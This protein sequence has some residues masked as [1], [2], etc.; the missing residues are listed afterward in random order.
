MQKT[1]KLMSNRRSEYYPVISY[2]FALVIIWLASW[3]ASVVQM[4]MFADSTVHSIVSAEGVRWALLSMHGSL[5]GVPWGSAL[6]LLFAAGLLTGSG[7]IH[8]LSRLMTGK[9]ISG[10]EVRSLLFSA[11]VLFLYIA[12]VFMFTVTPW[13]AMLG[14]T[15]E[16]ALSPLAQGW[17]LVLFVGVLVVSLVFGFMYGNYRTLA[18]VVGSA[19]VYMTIFLPAL[20]AMLPAA[21]I[22]PCLE[23]SGFA[24]MIGLDE[25]CADIAVELLCVFPF[26]YVAILWAMQKRER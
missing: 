10:N 17:M 16:V 15:G 24:A 5:N 18:D 14:V 19:G 25:E 21:G 11:L 6:L 7:I 9:K 26:L 12:I 8:S 20:M 4:F 1:L 2:T 13:R 23:Y 3:L 22:V